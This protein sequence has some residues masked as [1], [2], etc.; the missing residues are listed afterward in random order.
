M[1]VYVPQ[2]RPAAATRTWLLLIFLLPWPGVI[3]YALIGRIRVS[4]GQREKLARASR[5]IRKAEVAPREGGSVIGSAPAPYA[6]ASTLAFATG[7]FLPFIGNHIKLHDEYEQWI[8]QLVADI[9]AAQTR[10][11]L[12]FYIFADDETGQRVADALTR[13][14]DRG[15]ACRV[16]ID[17]VAGKSAF[18]RLVP[19]IRGSGRGR[20]RDAAHGTVQTE[21][22]AH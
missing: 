11:H 21:R 9:D 8:A 20:A 1:L 3:V 18:K 10:V 16:L 7:D 5:A 17:A 12:L 15:V 19:A 6:S 22:G 4:Q 2:Q 14:A 13:A